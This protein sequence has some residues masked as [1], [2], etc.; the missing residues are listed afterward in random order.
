MA[1]IE[2]TTP[3]TGTIASKGLRAPKSLTP[4]EIKAVSASALTQTSDKKPVPKTAARNA[5]A[6]PA[7][8]ARKTVTAKPLSRSQAAAKAPANK[9]PAKTGK[10]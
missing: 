6:A 8:S 4:R 9:V 7:P 10:K 1:K 3:K 5:P 2:K